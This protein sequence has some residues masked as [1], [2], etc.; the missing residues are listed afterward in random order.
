MTERRGLGRCGK[1]RDL[2]GG[3][4]ELVLVFRKQSDE[5]NDTQLLDLRNKE[6][7]NRKTF[8]IWKK[9]KSLLDEKMLSKIL[10]E[11]QSVD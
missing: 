6:A 7:T 4:K 2:A 11:V 9:K 10:K 8:V 5:E 1:Q 3:K